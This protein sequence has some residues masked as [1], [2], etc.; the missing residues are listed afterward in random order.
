MNGGAGDFQVKMA[1]FD[2]NH[3]HIVGEAVSLA[4]DVASDFFKFSSTD[5][6]TV[7]YDVQTLKDLTKDEIVAGALAQVMRYRQDPLKCPSGMGR[8]EY[9]KIGL[10]DHEILKALQR[11]E[12]ITLFPL[13]LYV[14]THELVHIVR[15]K[16]FLHNFYTPEEKKA[17]E[18][19]RVHQTTFDILKSV[20][21]S[22]M[23]PVLKLYQKHSIS[24]NIKEVR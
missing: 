14:I 19:R 17:D 9:Y 11:E 24:H 23:R 8:Y 2:Q 16:R 13:V 15:F 7:P 5:W 12:K 3:L 1:C 21:I 10:H 20:P 4:E 22:G 18:E 6:K